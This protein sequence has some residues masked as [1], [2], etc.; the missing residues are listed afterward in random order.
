MNTCL[1]CDSDGPFTTEHVIPFAMGNDDLILNDQ[2]CGNCN[3]YFSYKLES[4]VLTKSQIA[5]WRVHFGL[6]TRKGKFA[7]VDL[8][9][10]SEEKG[11]WPSVHE[12]HDVGIGFGRDHD[13]S[14]YVSIEDS[15]TIQQIISGERERFQ[16]VFTPKILV[17]LGRFFCKIGI[18]LICSTDPSQARLEMFQLARRFAR[19]GEMEG[20]WP[21]FHFSRGQ[22]SDFRTLHDDPKDPSEILETVELYRYRI[23]TVQQYVLLHFG[24]GTDNWVIGLNNPY[25]TPSILV[26]FPETKLDLIWY[27]G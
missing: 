16:F 3:N 6:K 25:P 12:A 9:Q 17:E 27:E 21:I 7:S 18:E 8:S 1:F 20:L 10:P 26:A 5:F 11:A 24:I 22:L 19:F 23:L 4:P 13:G 15:A 14:M 2:V